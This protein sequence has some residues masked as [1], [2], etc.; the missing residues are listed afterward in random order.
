[1]FTFFQGGMDDVRGHRCIRAGHRSNSPRSLVS[2]CRDN[3]RGMHAETWHDQPALYTRLPG[4]YGKDSQSPQ[5]LLL[6]AHP[7]SSR[8]E[9]IEKFAF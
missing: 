2:V 3:P 9:Y 4:R 8:F 5:S 6:P 7:C 1:M